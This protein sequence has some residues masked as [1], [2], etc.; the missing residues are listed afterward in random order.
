MPADAMTKSLA[1]LVLLFGLAIA[2]AAQT[3]TEGGE[4]R[5]LPTP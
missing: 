4:A 5:S 3:P 1:T 2:A